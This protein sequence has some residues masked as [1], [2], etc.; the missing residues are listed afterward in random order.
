M[1]NINP[2]TG[3]KIP[4]V[5][6]FHTKPTYRELRLQEATYLCFLSFASA[7]VTCFVTIAIRPSPSTSISEFTG[8]ELDFRGSVIIKRCFSR[9]KD[10]KHIIFNY[11]KLSSHIL[12]NQN[13]LSTQTHT[14]VIT[15][16]HVYAVQLLLFLKNPYL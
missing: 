16:T 3:G 10:S 12:H 5:L 11:L 13:I 15:Y 2:S 4:K 1:E 9:L 7:S 6:S 14:Y 8:D